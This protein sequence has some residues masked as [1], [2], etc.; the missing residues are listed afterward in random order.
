MMIMLTIDI[1]QSI[2]WSDVLT[3]DLKHLGT[4]LT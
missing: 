3:K 4:I 1:L 2:G